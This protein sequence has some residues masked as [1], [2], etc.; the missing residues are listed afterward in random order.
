[1]YEVRVAPSNPNRLYMITASRMWRSDD[2]GSTWTQVGSATYVTSTLD[3]NNASYRTWGQKMAVDPAN[4]DVV[5]AGSTNGLYVTTNGGGTWTQV[6][7]VPAPAAGAFITGIVFDASSGTT[8]GR[9]NVVYAVSH[10]TGVYR[11]DL[12]VNGGAWSLLAGG[13][14]TVAQGT[15]SSTGVYFAVNGGNTVY[16]YTA[17]AWTT[18]NVHPTSNGN[19]WGISVDPTNASR[20]IAIRESGHL[21]FST[22]GGATFTGWE[23]NQTL[24]ATD[25]PWLQNQNTGPGRSLSTSQMIFDPV[26]PG[27]V[28]FAEGTGVWYADVSARWGNP[29]AT[30]VW[31][32]HSLGIE[33]LV[34]FDVCVPPASSYVFVAGMDRSVFRTARANSSYP[35]DYVKMGATDSLIP[36]FEVDYSKT[37]PQHLVAIINAASYYVHAAGDLSGYSLD[38]GATWTRFPTQ[39]ASGF[40]GNIIAPSID[41][42]IA[43]IGIDGYAYRST[44]RGRSWTRLPGV[45]GNL[46]MGGWSVRRHILAVD[47]AYNGTSNTSMYLYAAG[48]GTWRSTDNGATWSQASTMTIPGDVWHTKLRSVPGRP[49][50]LFL[51]SGYQGGS[52]QPHP[53]WNAFLY[54][55]T[56]GGTTWTQVPNIGEPYDVAVGAPAPGQTYPAIYVAGW[57]NNAWGVWRSTDNTATWQ[58][59]G[60]EPSGSLDMITAMRAATDVYGEVYV[61]F[62]GSGWARGTLR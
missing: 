52:G 36:A 55:S 32:S 6:A 44:D 57:Y 7:G 53:F 38:G 54:R 3:P 56:D 34:G 35:S 49:G 15:I 9:T 28:W 47:G 10:G 39:P 27:K 45:P 48:S 5:Y 20:V 61:S 42:I 13:P 26:T 43:V 22:D 60:P 25:I 16:R 12:R 19:T 46:H 31:N 4:A 37:N 14:T 11:S 30:T 8:G 21:S 29:G 50:H 58:Q 17:G 2:R 40:G 18:A 41:N 24:S 33:Q 1:V 62:Q 51:A 59:I 23:W